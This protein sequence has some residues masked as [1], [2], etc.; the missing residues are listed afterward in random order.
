MLEIL[1]NIPE[2]L[3]EVVAWAGFWDGNSKR[4]R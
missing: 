2:L 3:L 1:G 4:N